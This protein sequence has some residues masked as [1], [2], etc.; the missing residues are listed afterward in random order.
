MATSRNMQ[1]FDRPTPDPRLDATHAELGPCACG[2]EGAPVPV[3]VY[4]EEGFRYFLDIERKRAEASNRP[5]LLLLLDLKK[6]S[7][8]TVDIDPELAATLFSALAT[9]LRETDFIGWYRAKSVVGAVL[10]QHTDSV[11]AEVQA[12]VRD[13]VG[14]I[15]RLELPREVAERVQVRVYRLP[16]AAAKGWN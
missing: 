12:V 7:L 8:A 5:F 11:G 15:L 9:C 3:E 6:A 4:N 13:R 2:F 14:A 1:P 10:T 16:P